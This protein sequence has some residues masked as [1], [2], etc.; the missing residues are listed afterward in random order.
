[1]EPLLQ[2]AGVPWLIRKAALAAPNPSIRT[3]MRADGMKVVSEGMAKNENEYK[4]GAASIHKTPAG[5]YPAEL[6]MGADGQSVVLVVRMAGKGTI[7][8]TYKR[9]GHLLVITMV[10][11]HEKNGKVETM[12]RV[13]VPRE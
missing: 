7:T 6:T 2:F 8:S 13:F 5:D 1:M 3:E 11:A 4:F 12:R 10:I 9:E